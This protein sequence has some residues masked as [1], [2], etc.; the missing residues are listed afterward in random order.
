MVDGLAVDPSTNKLYFTD[1]GAG[2]IERANLDGTVREQLIV[3]LRSPQGITVDV[4]G[5]MFYWVDVF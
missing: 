5:G 4:M 2:Q 1:F 3:G